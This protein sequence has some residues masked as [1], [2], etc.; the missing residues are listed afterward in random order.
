MLGLTPS[1]VSTLVAERQAR[2]AAEAAHGRW[3]R[4]LRQAHPAP[5]CAA[6]AGQL[7]EVVLDLTS[8]AAT[9]TEPAAT[10]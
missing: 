8:A 5:R 2:F 3:R 7:P 10:K 4:I 9:T 1:L 6:L